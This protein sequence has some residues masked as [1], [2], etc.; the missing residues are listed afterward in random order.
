MLGLFLGSGSEKSEGVSGVAESKGE[1]T[2]GGVSGGDGD[3]AAAKGVD[4]ARPL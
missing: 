4:G 1:F 3:G 2:R